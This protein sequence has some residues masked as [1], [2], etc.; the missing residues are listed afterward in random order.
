M[1]TYYGHVLTI[2]ILSFLV[3]Q[4]PLITCLLDSNYS[5]SK[6]FEIR[7]RLMSTLVQKQCST[8]VAT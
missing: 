3:P 6:L 4:L 5:Y 8:T 7:L 1:Y 2:L